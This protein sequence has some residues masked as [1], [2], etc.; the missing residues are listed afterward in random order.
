MAIR[1]LQGSGEDFAQSVVPTLDDDDTSWIAGASRCF[2]G[3]A[4]AAVLSITA[5]STAL[6]ANIQ[7][8]DQAEV[9]QP[10][11]TIV[12]ED[13][14]QQCPPFPAVA[15]VYRALQFL[16]PEEIPAGS[17]YG[18]FDE[19]FWN[20]PVAPV[21]PALYQRLPLYD[22]E[23]IPAGSLYGQFDEDFWQNPVVPVQSVLYRSPVLGDQEEVPAGSLLNGIPDEDFWLNP[24][25]P[26]AATLYQPLPYFFDPVDYVTL[27][28]PVQDEDFWLQQFLPPP[29]IAANYLRLP[30]LP[31]PEEIPA[32]SLVAANPD[33]DL[34]LAPL[35]KAPPP[36]LLQQ[37][38]F[39]SPEA[40]TS[41]AVDEDFWSSGV[42]PVP[43]SLYRHSSLLDP[44]E[45][46]AGNLYGVL[47]EDD[48]WRILAPPTPVIVSVPQPFIFDSGDTLL[49]FVPEDDSWR[50][51]VT[52][53][54]ASYYRSVFL[55]DLDEI[56]AG[57]L[58]SIVDEDFWINPVKPLY[59][60]YYQWLP[61]T[62]DVD[63]TVTPLPPVFSV[64]GTGSVLPFTGT[65]VASPNI[66][67][68]STLPITGTGKVR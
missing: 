4:L 25:K 66:G 6:A 20:N 1:Y 49:S 36:F 47:D 68:G 51:L 48:P 16:D 30:Y 62:S 38:T 15:I 11:T 9:P 14:W 46:P 43:A 54:A 17:L 42:A 35:P 44:E 29:V 41:Y 2:A 31:D 24:A 34:W 26:I 5:L 21:A 60:T 63:L 37:S 56:P 12:D 18:Q 27:S 22:V 32:N 40:V 45:I 61:L 3:V 10:T 13:Y 55:L 58:R 50:N 19:D 33:E 65:G 67:V 39:D 59:A 64:I 28:Q 52:P 53:V 8:V 57:S 23:E 7:Q